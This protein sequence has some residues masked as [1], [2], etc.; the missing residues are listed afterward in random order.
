MF[1]YRLF[2]LPDGN[3]RCTKN[4]RLNSDTS[5]IRN[6]ATTLLRSLATVCCRCQLLTTK[7]FDPYRRTLLY[8]RC[9]GRYKQLFPV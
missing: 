3:T 1:S 4:T 7:M 6:F 2:L 9:Y 5:S 8:C